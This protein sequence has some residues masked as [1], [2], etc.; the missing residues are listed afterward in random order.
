VL[1]LA[2]S[3]SQ[4]MTR[5]IHSKWIGS[6]MTASLELQGKSVGEEEELYYQRFWCL[7]VMPTLPS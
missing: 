1:W 6:A 3:S 5:V 7:V 4:S 2:R